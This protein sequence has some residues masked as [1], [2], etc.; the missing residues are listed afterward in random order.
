MP[1]RLFRALTWILIALILVLSLVPPS[2]R[3]V[4]G[5]P[6]NLE[7]FAIFALCGFC[8]GLGY[9]IRLTPAIGL[10]AFSA[11]VEVLQLLVPGRHARLV[12]LVV[13]SLACGAG[14]LIAW[15]VIRHGS[16]NRASCKR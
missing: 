12:D 16:L 1:L 4:T 6:H 5:A 14:M 11:V 2:L 9:G 10:A 8:F 3:P 7:H 13:D 15:L